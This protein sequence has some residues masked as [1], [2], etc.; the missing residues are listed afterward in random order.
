MIN[1]YHTPK[2]DTLELLRLQNRS[3]KYKISINASNKRDACDQCIILCDQ[4]IK[5]KHQYISVKCSSI[6]AFTTNLLFF[7]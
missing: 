2:V 1:N 7:E 5:R 4:C 3:K 6:R